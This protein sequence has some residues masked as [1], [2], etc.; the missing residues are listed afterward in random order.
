MIC[1][2]CGKTLHDL[3]TSDEGY[4]FCDPICR[5]SW[6]KNGKPNP[7]KL[8]SGTKDN[9]HITQIDSD[10]HI[11]PQGFENRKMIIHLRHFGKPQIYLDGKVLPAKK[12]LLS[13]FVEFTAVNNYGHIVSLRLR[14]MPFNLAPVLYIDNQPFP[15]G[16]QLSI[17]EMVWMILPLTLMFI[18]GAIGGLIGGAALVSNFILM[19]KIK[20]K[21]LRYLYTGMT[22]I[23]AAVLWITIGGAAVSFINSFHS[24]DKQL[25]EAVVVL[26][27]S[28]P[29]MGDSETRIDSVNSPQ[30]KTI[31]YYYT[32]VNK[33]K[34]ELDIPK[35]RAA[36]T[37]H[38][39]DAIKTKDEL[40]SFR[41]NSVTFIY[42]YNDKN[43]EEVLD[44][45][46]TPLDY[47]E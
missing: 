47:K 7:A 18:G 45:R 39:I 16:R 22:T 12:K 42:K 37:P 2:N 35:L 17:F 26:N 31:A 29:Q 11:E 9:P 10:F 46:A 15:F 33:S 14:K 4:F 19:Q 43:N 36:L 25:K 41:E 3:T 6:Q 1:A 21:S 5:Y 38:I 24:V 28:Y 40:R 30:E 13:K 23:M 20:Q 27:K 34:D 32:L 8:D 44:I